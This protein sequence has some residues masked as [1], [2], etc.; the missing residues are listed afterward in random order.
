L[1]PGWYWDYR[2]T[3]T[4]YYSTVKAFSDRMGRLPTKVDVSAS[5]LTKWYDRQKSIL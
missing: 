5:G 2:D 4:R 3:W 1:L